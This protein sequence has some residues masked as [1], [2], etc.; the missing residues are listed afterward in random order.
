MVRMPRNGTVRWYYLAA[1]SGYA[2]ATPQ[3]IGVV[4]NGLGPAGWGRFV[5]DSILG[6]PVH[7]AGDIHDWMYYYRMGKTLADQIFWQNMREIILGNSRSFVARWLRL[8]M[9]RIFY[10]CV[11]YGGQKAYG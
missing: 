5:P 10:L 6:L 9:A 4:S 7:E 11:K 8:G 1:P 3:H 2:S